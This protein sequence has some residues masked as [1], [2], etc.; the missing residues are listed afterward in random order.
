MTGVQDVCSSDLAEHAPHGHQADAERYADDP[1]LAAGHQLPPILW[2]VRPYS[3]AL[4]KRTG[5]V[6]AVAIRA[7]RLGVTADLPLINP[8]FGALFGS[9]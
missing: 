8:E 6:K 5:A 4:Q 3:A 9:H 1:H 2:G 7:V